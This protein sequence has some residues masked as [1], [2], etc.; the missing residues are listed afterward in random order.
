MGVEDTNY[1]IP[2]LNANTTF[3]DWVVKENDEIIEKLNLLNIYNLAGSTGIDVVA[4][5]GGTA[6]ISVSDTISGVT[7]SGDLVVT[8]TIIGAPVTSVNGQTGAVTI[9]LTGDT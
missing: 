4:A 7:V 3:Y 2:D 5:T 8:G 6:T 1:D 9:A